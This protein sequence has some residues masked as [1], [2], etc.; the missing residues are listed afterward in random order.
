MESW[1]RSR[2]VEKP[3]TPRKV[4]TIEVWDNPPGLHT[5]PGAYRAQYVGTDYVGYGDTIPQA[6]EDLFDRLMSGAIRA[7]TGFG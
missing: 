7:A 1:G 6:V 2:E 5:K 3:K 4:A